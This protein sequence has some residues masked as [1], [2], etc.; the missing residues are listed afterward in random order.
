[1]ITQMSTRGV[2]HSHTSIIC[3]E[4]LRVMYLIMDRSSIS[5][6]QGVIEISHYDPFRVGF[7]DLPRHNIGSNFGRPCVG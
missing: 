2:S 3:F 7:G 5:E 1:M 6:N 4:K